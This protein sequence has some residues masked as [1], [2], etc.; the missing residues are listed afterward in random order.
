MYRPIISSK[1]LRFSFAALALGLFIASALGQAQND[2]R[3]LSLNQ[4]VE[5]ALKVGEA[6]TY[7]VNL[8]AGQFMRAEVNQSAGFDVIV[9][10][11]APDG[12]LLIDMN[13]HNGLLWREAVSCIALIDGAYKI[14]VKPVEQNAG[15]GN[16]SIT[17][18]GLRE[19]SEQDRKR[20]AAEKVFSEGRNLQIANPQASAEVINKF[21]TA[22][23]LWRESG[24]R[25]WEAVTLT[26]LGWAYSDLNQNEKAV[27]SLSQA[28]KQ[29]QEIKDRQ[30]EGKAANGLGLAHKGL[31]QYEKARD[32]YEQA[33][34]I[35]RELKDRR[36]EGITLSNLGEIYDDLNQEAK[37]REY[38]EQGL[39]I[40]RE[41]KNRSGESFAL[42]RLAYTY[43]KPSTQNLDKVKE[44]LELTLA[45]TRDSKDKRGERNIIN[46]LGIYHLNFFGQYEKAQDYFER[47]LASYKDMPDKGG[48]S[49]TLFNLGLIQLS[50]TSD[51]DK[52]REYFERA[53]QIK[54]ELKDRDGESRMLSNLA[55]ACLCL[56]QNEKLRA[57]SEQAL[58]IKESLKDRVG[59]IP[60]LAGLGSSYANSGE[61]EKAQGY[62]EQAL[63]IAREEKERG[64]EILTLGMLANH[65]KALKQFEKARS[66]YEQALSV[67]RRSKDKYTSSTLNALAGLYTDLKQYDKAQDHYEQALEIATSLNDKNGQGDVLTNASRLYVRLH[68]FDKAQSYLERALTIART[69]SNRYREVNILNSLGELYKK[70]NR[71]EKAL[72]HHEE[73][74]KASREINNPTNENFS[75]LYMG[76]THSDL[77]QYEKAQGYLEQSL[78][79]SRETKNL[80]LEC[81]ALISLGSVY[82]NLNQYEKARDYYEHGLTIAKGI[83][84]RELEGGTISAIGAVYADLNQNERAR[85]IYNQSL[86]MMKEVLNRQGEG[87]IRNALGY[88]YLNLKQYEKAKDYYEQALAIAR[89]GKEKGDEANALI[90]L[91][92]AY[93]NLNQ[94]EKARSFYER[95]L[96]LTREVRSRRGESYALNGLGNVNERL[97]RPEKAQDYYRQALTIAREI[98]NKKVEG[99]VLWNLMALSSKGNDPRL[100]IFYGKQAVNAFQE[101]RGNIRSFDK[102]SQQSFLSDKES[103]YR[104]LADILISEGRLAEAQAVLDLLKEEEFRKLTGRSGEPIFTLPYSKAE[105]EVIRVIENLASLG[106]E[107]GELRSKRNHTEEE[108]ARFHELR[109]ELKKAEEALQQA[110]GTLAASAPDVK[111]RLAERMREQDV[112]NILPEL[113]KGVVALYTV[114]GKAGEAKKASGPES[115]KATIGWV[116]LVTGEF[117]KAYPIDTKDLERTVFKFREALRS[118]QYDPRPL[119]QSLYRKLFLQTSERQKTTLAADLET[120][121]GDQKDK[122]LMW[123]LDG[124]LRYVPMA[125][126]HDG[127]QYL[128][129]KYRNVIFNTQSIGRLT[130]LPKPGWEALGLGVSE[131]KTVTVDGRTLVFPAL[132][133][134]ESEINLLV[135]KRDSANGMNGILPG[136]IKMNRDFTKEA[137]FE[138]A[139][140]P[141]SVIH[142][143]SHFWFNPANA[144]LSFL[145]LGDGTALHMTEFE[146]DRTLFRNVDLLSLAACDTATGGVM[147]SGNGPGQTNGEEVEGFAYKAQYLGAKSVLASLWQVSDEGT[148]E[149]MVKFYRTRQADPRL[150]KGE[151]LRQSQLALLNGSYKP[152]AAPGWRG[153]KVEPAGSGDK[154]LPPFA[155]DRNAPHAHPYYWAPFVLIGNWR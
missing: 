99:R 57:Y 53:L 119:A 23:G 145:L 126:L 48:E 138:I 22:L 130:D 82:F 34:A 108:T 63:A 55:T 85:N 129:E 71:Y 45:I 79:K 31:R 107:I 26:N 38:Y 127:K 86:A 75:L 25:Y 49:E 19:P 102:E 33:L 77:N 16:Y 37:A 141:R 64:F 6:H 123:S 144:E 87:Q 74:L 146:N 20:V 66:L 104:T 151:A 12:K 60:L 65:Y 73:A 35:R 72:S 80:A 61:N 96:S 4:T 110:L 118:P 15:A 97:K 29:F 137:L 114:I 21:E 101:I 41:V 116:L 62:Y 132:T 56:G 5:R 39:A 100:A 143:A 50:G 46:L 30:S 94:P 152:G 11:Y 131:A 9:S 78:I 47:S 69:S 105:E 125:A 120:Y 18:V 103:A 111:G 148:K 81:I 121:I 149:L 3:V 135:K 58:S 43:S 150:P 95:G 7:Q 68:Q 14:E 36:G 88:T 136:V 42:L 84:N 134:A 91:G 8:R 147:K 93:S 51:C 17:V 115:E 109:I 59:Q 70:L 54:R 139:L 122:T 44:Y 98:K 24:D 112:Q 133:G 140:A 89:E 28:L 117:R 155:Y 154:Q 52:A 76:S 13:A 27:D 92:D 83:K 1:S 2:V 106:R 113:G 153:P 90:N 142:I 10:L 128:V 40:A 32:Y 124:I 67:A